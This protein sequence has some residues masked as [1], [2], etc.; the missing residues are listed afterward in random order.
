MVPSARRPQGCSGW[1][2]NGHLMPRRR[3]PS[4]RPR[5]VHKEPR[6]PPTHTCTKQ[7]LSLIKVPG[8][9]AK[10]DF[11]LMSGGGGC[12]ETKRGFKFRDC[13]LWP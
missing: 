10:R 9:E 7:G 6:Y 13:R 5:S 12:G 2:A 11:W 8:Y 3:R 1:A 4:I